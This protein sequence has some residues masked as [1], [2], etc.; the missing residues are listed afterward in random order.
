[1][2]DYEVLELRL[3]VGQVQG[4][5]K[6]A[7]RRAGGP[8]SSFMRWMRSLGAS[9]SRRC[10]QYATRRIRASRLSSRLG[11]GVPAQ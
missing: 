1:M 8:T 4:K 11:I 10:I 2:G 6:R 5:R 9:T 3:P 7:G